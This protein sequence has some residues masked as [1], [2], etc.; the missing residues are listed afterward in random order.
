MQPTPIKNKIPETNLIYLYDLP[1]NQCTSVQLAKVIK[2]LTGYS[3]DHNHK[4]QVRRDPARPFYSAIIKIDNP[5]KFHDVAK[6]LRFFSLEDKPCRALPYCADL[7][8]S[9]V[10][11]IN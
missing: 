4:P 3:L 11:K 2:E 1:K 5:E 9:N 7:L 10:S 8:G 6:K